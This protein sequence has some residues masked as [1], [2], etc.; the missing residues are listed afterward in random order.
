MGELSTNPSRK[1]VDSYFFCTYNVRMNAINTS[2]TTSGNSVAVRLPK[3]LL[4][5]SGLGNKVKLEARQGKIIISKASNP[6]EGW[7][8]QIKALVIANGNPAEEFNDMDSARND[9]LADLPWDGPSFEDWQK[10]NV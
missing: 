10:Q 2:L 7:G 5:M 8:D 3:E 9:G 1:V 6:R 4:R